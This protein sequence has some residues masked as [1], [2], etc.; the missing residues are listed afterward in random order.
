MAASKEIEK[1]SDI[2][3]EDTMMQEKH[4][5]LGGDYSGAVK[6]TDPKEIKLC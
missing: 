3:V 5:E 2:Y 1:P 4:I 6:K